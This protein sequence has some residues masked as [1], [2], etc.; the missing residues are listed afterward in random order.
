MV[1]QVTMTLILSITS[2]VVLVGPHASSTE[3]LLGNYY[4]NIS[5]AIV[6]PLQAFQVPLGSW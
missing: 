2:Q 3:H 5:G 6:S 1:L 4:G